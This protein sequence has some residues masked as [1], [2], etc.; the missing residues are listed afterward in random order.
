[1][2]NTDNRNTLAPFVVSKAS[3][4]S[5][6][7]Y[8]LVLEYLK[9]AMTGPRQSL[10][11]R[12]AGI[13]PITFT[14]KATGEMK[15]R[16]VKELSV[17]ARRGVDPSDSKAFGTRLLDELNATGYFSRR[18]ISA[19]EL[20]SMAAELQQAMLHNYTDLSVVTIDSFMTRIV[21][22]FAHDFGQPVKFE[23]SLDKET[24][25]ADAVD[26][27]MSLVGTEADNELTQLLQDYADSNMEDAQG[28]NVEAAI[29]KLAKLLFS[30]DI[31][32]R[33]KKLEGLTMADFRD[34]H[35]RYVAANRAVEERLRI[36]GTEL[37]SIVEP[38]GLTDADCYK[39]RGAYLKWFRLLADGRMEMPSSSVEKPLTGGT[40]VSAKCD[41]ALAERLEGLRPQLEDGYRRAIDYI[42]QNLRPYNTR[43]MILKKL[44]STALLG[45]LRSLM[46]DISRE[47]QT[48]HLAEFNRMIN[49]VVEDEDNP[50]PFIFERL[51][52]R[53]RHFLIDEFQDTSVMQWHNLVPLLEDAVS[54]GREC[55]VV[56]DAKQA[57]YRFR[58]GD[59][60][61][62]VALPKVEGMR[63]HGR[64]LAL[65]GN[66]RMAHLDTNYRTLASVVGF[67]NDF[68]SWLVRNHFGDN[69]L[70]KEMYLGY[71]A[72]G[73]FRAEGDEELRQKNAKTATGHVGVSI[74]DD[75]G[76]EKVYSEVK[77]IIESLVSERGYSY[78]DIMVLARSN[79][80]LASFSSWLTE[81]SAIP[82]TS[83]QSFMV[84]SS[85]AALA[86]VAALRWLNNRRDRVAEA[87]LRQRLSNLGMHVREGDE[88]PLS[89]EVDHLLALD[90]YSL[91][92]ELVRRL[93]LDG[94]DQPYLCRLLDAAADFTRGH[95]QRIDEFLQWLDSHPD[96]SASTSDELDAVQL[97]S[98][99]KAKGLQ[100]PV[101]I[102]LL[103][104]LSRKFPE[105]WVDL[106]PE[107]GVGEKQLPTAYVSFSSKKESTL[108]DQ[109]D[110]E[111][112]LRDADELNIL[113][114]ALT[115]PEEQLFLVCKNGNSGY[116][117]W[118]K[119]YFGQR[120][121][122]E[123]RAHLGDAGFCKL[124]AKPGDADEE[125]KT[126]VGLHRVS[127]PDWTTRVSIA[128]PSER[129]AAQLLDDRVRFGIYAH[130]LMSGIRSSA[131]VDDAVAAFRQ[132]HV[133][134]DDE[135]AALER[136]ARMAVEH[137]DARRFF[138]PGNR[139]VNEMT[140]LDR[141]L[142]S[143][144]DRV[145]IGK[146][147]T[148]VV[149]FKTGT[150]V[151]KN[152]EQVRGYCQAVASMG[153]ANVS[154]WLM[155]LHP[156]GV[157]V[158][159]VK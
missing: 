93:Q 123:G 1:M 63:N 117:L 129:A 24:L 77:S 138:A 57:I 5:G 31:D 89:S 13:L 102:C 100:K 75:E 80:Q 127:F 135:S 119:E 131:D 72:N 79:K 68:F 85:E 69:T 98:I 118:L 60:R 22:T 110:S 19:G 91:C 47:G 145:V 11:T 54:Q 87:E 55:F 66:S 141:G 45:R 35:R 148:W 42:G 61:Q 56:G 16:I 59:V 34:I 133:L 58:Q 44:Y 78:R 146:D 12:F 43:A 10:P 150:P 38:L 128:S 21:R 65:P 121:D 103:I 6:K 9:L 73:G 155:Y 142:V 15:A 149:D 83:R 106:P 108:G 84:H 50:A 125:K 27:L 124:P 115:R 111:M 18:T 157:D 154:G 99:H 76:L 62:F 25:I 88:V 159:E 96:L 152:A 120:I 7:T 48:L 132:R 144:P 3:A 32:A 52:N 105:M 64:T 82:Q 94:V 71:D 109:C 114:V 130:E 36:F 74:V 4:G 104:P 20:Q 33:L 137:P 41:P 70:A 95:R 147:A 122:A 17:I 158:V 39:G 156:D 53:Y 23:L 139:V 97:M 37:L 134:E 14:N 92:E 86:V 143:R 2:S 112:A 8:N 46:A 101:V 126:V 67:N 29:V 113:Y 49:G 116:P 26:R 136:L 51:G 81:H 30:E 107:E 90:L 151:E 153:Y 140:I 28:Y 40:L